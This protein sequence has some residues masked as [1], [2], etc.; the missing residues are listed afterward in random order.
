MHCPLRFPLLA[1]TAFLLFGA[2]G[3]HM[4]T[5]NLTLSGDEIGPTSYGSPGS[6]SVQTTAGTQMT[7]ARDPESGSTSIEVPGGSLLIANPVGGD[8]GTVTVNTAFG[9]VELPPGG[10]LQVSVDPVTGVLQVAVLAGTATVAGPGG[11]AQTLS[12]PAFALSGPGELFSHGGVGS[13]LPTSRASALLSGLIE[14][15][16]LA[17]GNP[18][19]LET[20]ARLAEGPGQADRDQLARFF[21]RVPTRFEQPDFMRNVLADPSLIAVSES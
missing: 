18:S 2:V 9:S 8:L 17:R 1:A 20:L 4:L 7:L 19:W 16:V 13:A 21:G 14:G 6:G 10:V 11:Q 15:S 3:P 5:A 12:G